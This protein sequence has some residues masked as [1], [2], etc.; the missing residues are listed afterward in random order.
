MTY[1]I[2]SSLQI[3]NDLALAIDH[4][5]TWGGN[6]E[7]TRILETDFIE[8]EGQDFPYRMVIMRVEVTY[9][10]QKETRT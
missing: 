4:N 7:W 3:H 2:K 8:D 6:A 9:R 5:E 1:E 10:A